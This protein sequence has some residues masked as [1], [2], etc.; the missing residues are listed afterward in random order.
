MLYAAP[1]VYI[2]LMDGFADIRVHGLHTRRER[3]LNLSLCV[4]LYT[5]HPPP[6]SPFPSLAHSLSLL[7]ILSLPSSPSPIFFFPFTLSSLPL[8]IF[9][10]SSPHHKQGLS[11]EYTNST[12]QAFTS[13]I[14]IYTNMI[15]S[16]EVFVFPTN[17]LQA[18]V[19][20]EGE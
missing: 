19:M 16:L 14:R 4:F 6:I 13:Q 7:L 3:K 20:E 10:S 17:V 15:H 2:W 9:F 1:R 8:F 5:S 12:R 18:V 11:H